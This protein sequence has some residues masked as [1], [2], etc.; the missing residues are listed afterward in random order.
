MS[1]FAELA[2]N[3]PIVTEKLACNDNIAKALYFNEPDFLSQ[4]FPIDFN[5]K[6][7][8][9]NKIYPYQF[10]PDIEDKQS[11]FITMDFE[12]EPC[13]SEYRY[14]HIYFYIIVH[15]NLLRND[16]GML[17]HHYILNQ[18]DE[19]FNKIRNISIGK[20]QSGRAKPFVF[21]NGKW[22]GVSMAYKAVDFQ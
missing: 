12:F 7:L 6:S 9:Y 21:H 8:V 19:T 5:R 14:G 4:A 3:I 16:T 22:L 20:L 2:T 17:R 11:S 10:I 1:R 13:G 15:K 18:L